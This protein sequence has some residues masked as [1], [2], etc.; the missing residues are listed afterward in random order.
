MLWFGYAQEQHD[1]CGAPLKKPFQ[2]SSISDLQLRKHSICRSWVPNQE[3]YQPNRWQYPDWSYKLQSYWTDLWTR[4][5]KTWKSMWQMK[6]QEKKNN[7]KK[8][9]W[10]SIQVLLKLPKYGWSKE[11]TKN[12]DRYFKYG[13]LVRTTTWMFWLIKNCRKCRK[14]TTNSKE[15]EFDITEESLMKYSQGISILKRNFMPEEQGIS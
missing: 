14:N 15:E 2:S 10:P 12:N 6:M 9:V 11:N 5:K 4:L 7:E 13:R 3:W 8:N 1:F